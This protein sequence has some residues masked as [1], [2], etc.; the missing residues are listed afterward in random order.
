MAS[1]PARFYVCMQPRRPYSCAT[2]AHSPCAE[3]SNSEGYELAE[4]GRRLAEA[5]VG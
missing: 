2:R 4:A 1:R 5:S 3:A